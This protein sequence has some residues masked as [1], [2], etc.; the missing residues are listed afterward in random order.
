M[1]TNGLSSFIRWNDAKIFWGLK[2][3]NIVSRCWSW[4]G[5]VFYWTCGKTAISPS[6]ILSHSDFLEKNWVALF[7]ADSV[8]TDKEFSRPIWVY[9]I[10][11]E[12]GARTETEILNQ[13][14]AMIFTI[15]A[16]KE[17]VWCTTEIWRIISGCAKFLVFKI[18]YQK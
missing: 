3:D 14:L 4:Q 12:C 1:K 5:L 15:Q 2:K 16:L 8:R 7:E 9:V 18:N 17:D 11:V 10:S 13:V 6:W